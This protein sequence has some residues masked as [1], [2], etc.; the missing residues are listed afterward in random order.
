[1]MDDSDIT[2]LAKGMV[3]FVRDCVSEV[4]TPLTARIAEFEARPIPVAEKGADGLPGPAG[5]PGPKGDNGELAMLP[6]ELAGQVALAV[7]M[8]HES[9][10]IEQRSSAPPPSTRVTRIERDADGNF[11]PVYDETQP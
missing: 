7:R 11:V 9:P 3:P 6:P 2:E 5:P 10:P 4:V 1:M 8:L